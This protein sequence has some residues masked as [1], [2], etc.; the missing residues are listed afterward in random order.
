MFAA[1]YNEGEI[2]RR[3]NDM[4][5]AAASFHRAAAVAEEALQPGKISQNAA[6]VRTNRRNALR[7]FTAAGRA[8]AGYNDLHAAEKAF[9]GAVR[10][11]PSDPDSN[12][13]RAQLGKSPKPFHHDCYHVNHT[14]SV[15]KCE[16]F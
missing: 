5:K 10:V 12:L 13:Y 11:L 9:A 8:T 2:Y 4:H 3:Q 14:F 15:R 7:G 1:H 6:V 16:K